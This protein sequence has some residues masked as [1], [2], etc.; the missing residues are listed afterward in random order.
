MP[1][2]I[3]VP[4]MG[5]VEFPDGM[6]DDQIASA[7]KSN[8]PATDKRSGVQQFMQNAAAG[9]VRGAGSIGATILTP[10]DKLMGNTQSWGNP[11]RRQAMDDAFRTMGVD[12]E[13][14]GYG[15]GK[16]IGEIAG[17]AGTGG[18]LARGLA[19]VPGL[20]R[21]AP[22]LLD[23]VGSSGFTAGGLAGKTGLAA[24]AAGG[25]LTGG[26]AAGLV[27]PEDA[28]L[29]AAVGGALP[30]TLQAAGWAGRAAARPFRS[31]ETKAAEALAKALEQDPQALAAQLRTARQL[32]PGSRP[33]VS[34]VLRTP[35]AGTLERIV[36]ETPGGALLK[37]QYAQQNAARL[38]ALDRVAP[39]DAR[40]FRSVQEDFGEAALKAIR[41]DDKQ[42]RAATS[43][44]Y[45]SIPQD[46]AAL[47][48]PDL[49]SVRDRYFPAGSF[50]GR[51]S[52]DQAVNVAESIG[53]EE[54][55]GLLAQT[56]GKESQ[57]LAQAVR[58]AGG[59]SI[60]DNSGLRGEVAGLRGD[61]KNL[62][63]VNGGLSPAA[64]AERMQQRGFLQT[65]NTDE[66]FDML[67]AESRGE[68]TGSIYGD[69]TKAWSAARD[70]AMG[71]P[72]GAT[73][74]P[75]KVTLGE[76][77]ALRKSIGN[78]QRGAGR[79]PERATEALA[80][81]KMRSAL[82]D[83]IDEVVRGDGA[84]DENLPI[85]WADALT[86]AQRLKRAQVEK[87]RT[88]PQSLAFKTGQDGLP[89]VQ[90]GEFA[91]K[92]WG[93]RA[94]IASDIR[95]FKKAI[96]DHPQVLEQFQR[97]VTTEGASTATAGG[98][99]TSKF[100]KWVD[101]SLPGLKEVFKPEEVKAMQRIAA[102]IKRS[103][104]AS[105]I[106]M[107]K[108]SPTYQNAAGA[109]SLGVLDSPLLNIMATRTP[110]IGGFTGPMLSSL[111]ESGKKAKAEQLAGLL[112]D[113]TQAA[114]AMGGLLSAPSLRLDLLR[115]GLLTSSP[116]VV[117]D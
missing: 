71:P 72:P 77:D 76:F 81:G 57:S 23:A 44:A 84:I 33:T 16:L 70:A 35:Q 41:G 21:A 47:Y 66:L 27:N 53:K 115:R 9:L 108:G 95:Q 11:E 100:V 51:A 31:A 104:V 24:R 101:G 3:E 82:D 20:A 89:T 94:G 106:G 61:L 54:L 116:V 12:T 58:Q 69:N 2:R 29:G 8:M 64:M 112:S 60:K 73:T 63:R 26:A 103:E 15:G 80:L 38:A 36:S 68:F 18:M 52:V 96:E 40:G 59:I 7:I 97:M 83:R 14:L 79:D 105:A 4:G 110:I 46:E 32:V 62:V 75:K 114:D 93:Q 102:D 91:P 88:G 92:V 39:T 43:A 78:A 42:A 65:D 111:R 98:N 5:I 117:A 107:A 28:G 85:A 25:G 87:F 34:Q 6:T 37:E 113:P 1:Q 55:P 49:V 90:G 19:A 10:I 50:G 74:V 67:R 30:G 17:T 109:L 13:S 56:G 99:L 48:L 45:Q 22:G 86:E